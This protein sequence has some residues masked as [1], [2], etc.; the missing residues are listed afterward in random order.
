M[1][2]IDVIIEQNWAIIGL[3][4]IYSRHLSAIKEINDKVLMTCDIDPSKK[5]DFI[6]WVEMIK[7][8][9]F[10][11]VD[12]VAVLTPNYTHS[13]I[14]RV[15][16][17]EGKRVLCEKPLTIFG[18][19][20]GLENINIV[21]QL[22]HNEKIKELKNKKIKEIEIFVKT[23][24]EPKYFESWKGKKEKS[25]GILWNMGI[26]Y[27]DLLCYLLGAPQKIISSKYSERLAKGEVVFKNGIGKYHIELSKELCETERKM[28]VD[29]QE[30]DIEGATI[31]LSD[32]GQYKNLHTEAYKQFKENP[33]ECPT[34][35]D[36][37]FAMDLVEKLKNYG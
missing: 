28:I 23:Y 5:A 9:K 12:N 36:T 32:K 7:S 25:G 20:P 33:S 13:T 22:R 35:K 17:D 19:Y 31:P 11:L 26:H 3:G 37:Y 2:Q 15:L 21:L 30:I 29:G 16:V 27:I 6:D 34:L 1:L 18:D 8:D 4:F 24:R 10:K 14:C